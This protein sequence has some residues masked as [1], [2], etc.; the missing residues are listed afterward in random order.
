MQH[1]Q[2]ANFNEGC[3]NLC[4]VDTIKHPSFRSPSSRFC[5]QQLQVHFNRN[6]GTNVDCLLKSPELALTPAVN[7]SRTTKWVQFKVDPRFNRHF[8]QTH[9][10]DAS[11]PKKQWKSLLTP[12]F[13]H[14]LFHSGSC[15]KTLSLGVGFLFVHLK[16][17]R[18]C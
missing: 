5:Y 17:D 15:S 8:L 12:L 4:C 9:T 18:Y 11:Y 3:K 10:S 16:T 6:V 7:I 13:K 14:I 2:A 1:Q